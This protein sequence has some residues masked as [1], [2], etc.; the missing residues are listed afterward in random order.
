MIN[1]YSLVN[2]SFNCFTIVMKT[3]DGLKSKVTCYEK[4]KIEMTEYFKQNSNTK[5]IGVE[6]KQFQQKTAPEFVVRIK[7]MWVP[8][9]I[10]EFC[11]LTPDY[12][13]YQLQLEN[14]F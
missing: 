4:T 6:T 2:P 12:L 8:Y 14:Q 3:S 11:V 1:W 9:L 7:K 13:F 10:D 5:S